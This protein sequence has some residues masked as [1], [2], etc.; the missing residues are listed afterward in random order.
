MLYINSYYMLLIAFLYRLVPSSP[1]CGV[2][3]LPPV[4]VWG[5]MVRLFVFNYCDQ[6]LLILVN[7]LYMSCINSVV[8]TYIL[9]LR[10][11]VRTYRTICTYSIV[12]SVQFC[13]LYILCIPYDLYILYTLYRTVLDPSWISRNLRPHQLAINRYK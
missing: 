7:N 12:H 6:K 10:D 5:E 8:R 9:Y 1:V 11:Y 13:M 4:F 2:S 3:G